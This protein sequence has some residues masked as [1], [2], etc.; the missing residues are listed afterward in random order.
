MRIASS[1]TAGSGLHF[2]VQTPTQ[3][4]ITPM[5]DPMD[6]GE[7]RPF[8]PISIRRKLLH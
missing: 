7:T 8:L 6:A 1:P 5:D 2:A 3:F 4:A